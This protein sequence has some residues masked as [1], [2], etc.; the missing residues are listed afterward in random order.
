MGSAAEV[1]AARSFIAA[2]PCLSLG[3]IP[4]NGGQTLQKPHLQGG[5]WI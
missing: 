4:S 5:V 3:E 2:C 1:P